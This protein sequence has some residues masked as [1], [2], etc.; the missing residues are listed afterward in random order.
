MDM[1]SSKKYTYNDFWEM[2]GR[3]SIWVTQFVSYRI[4]ALLA[5]WAYKAKLT[6]NIISVASAAITVFSAMAAVYLGQESWVAGVVLIVGLQLGYALDCADG[7]LARATGK[8]SSFGTLIDKISDLSSA[9]VFPC[10][11]AY[12]AGHYYYQLED[13]RPDY[14]LRVL[15]TALIL[16]VVLS[17]LLWLKELVVYRA[18]RLQED[19][20][21][22]T[23]WWKAKRC[24]GLY[25]DEP[26]YRLGISVAWV[27]FVFWEF[28]IIYSVGIF[29][30]SLIYFFASKRE[31]DE[32][33]RQNKLKQS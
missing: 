22:H 10:V 24:V 1:G 29:F 33:D 17:V 2:R 4:G 27:M 23:L 13:S 11:L 32:M 25:I 3:Q 14:T 9:L 5:L 8:T 30:I 12:G 18:D 28:I 31:M 6:P 26:I 20:R 15:L 16:R 19:N 7:P 21:Q